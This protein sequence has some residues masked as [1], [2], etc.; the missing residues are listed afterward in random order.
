MLS[1]LGSTQHACDRISRREMLR[2]GGLGTLGL[3]LPAWLEARA[4]AAS[5]SRLARSSTSGHAMPAKACILI[6]MWG[7]PAHQDTWD[8]KP[9]GP[10]AVRGEFQPIETSAPGMLISEH[11]PRIARHGRKLAI[12]RSV[13]H[14]DNNHSTGAHAM[15]TGRVHRISAEN[16]GPSSDDFPHFGSVLSQL[17][18]S[19]G[20]LPSFV[21]LPERI[22][23]T[24]GP[25]VPGQ[26]GGLL[27]RR[28]DPFTI[29]QHPE[30]PNF[31]VPSLQLPGEVTVS[32][33]EDRR[34]LLHGV[35]RL[36][37]H[38]DRSRDVA[39][40]SSY[41]AQALDM[42]TSPA[43][44]KA[45]DLAQE[46][47]KVRELYGMHTFGQSCLLARRLIEAGVR[48]VTIYWHRDKPGVDTTW[49][50]HA[51]NFPQLKERLMPQSDSGFAALLDDLAQR[52]LLDETLVVWTSEFGRTPKINANGGRDHW[53]P[54]NSVIFAGGGV[55][56][57]QVYGATD[58]SASAPAR[59]AVSPDDIAATIYTLLGIPPET[60]I[61]DPLQRPHRVAL[62][63]P[64]RQ[65][66]PH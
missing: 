33:L 32:R 54:A 10:S 22:R 4:A 37:G 24:S 58:E 15:L 66:L 46:D 28:Y 29:D 59:D 62:G 55:P 42:I 8:L 49:D 5:P 2:I 13:T 47:P 60:E 52:G 12:V 21:A 26:G 35:D 63:Q 16:F 9:E 44:R 27:G 11:F 14:K 65:L 45:F 19:A 34:R 41:Y 39:A 23:T 25:F 48:L 50:T 53:G 56:G 30:E 3:S 51:K 20:G 40:L 7:G 18:P 43:T 17:R 61:R 31:A 1:I 38:L 6:Y 57:G 36:A 64:I